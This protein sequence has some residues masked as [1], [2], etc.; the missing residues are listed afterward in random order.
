MSDSF[1]SALR[2]KLD[3]ELVVKA[4]Q[5]VLNY[6]AGESIVVD[7]EDKK[8]KK[9]N[10]LE[11]VELQISE[12]I[13]CSQPHLATIPALLSS[14]VLFNLRISSLHLSL[15]CFPKLFLI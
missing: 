1:T 10:F 14:L 2:S 12:C 6:S 7:G 4:I 15:L 13:V 5:N 3:Q 11:T 8:G 9:R